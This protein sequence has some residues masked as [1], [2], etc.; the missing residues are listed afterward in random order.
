MNVWS[1]PL[2]LHEPRRWFSGFER[3]NS[4]DEMKRRVVLPYQ[5]VGRLRGYAFWRGRH[6]SSHHVDESQAVE[7]GE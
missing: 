3:R 4:D 6:P 2:I 7:I 5:T 1:V